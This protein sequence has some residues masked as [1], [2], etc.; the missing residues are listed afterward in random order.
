MVGKWKIFLF[1]LSLKQIHLLAFNAASSCTYSKTI[2]TKPE[3]ACT[4]I[5]SSPMP[6]LFALDVA[7]CWFFD[8]NAVLL[9][10]H[11]KRTH[12]ASCQIGNKWKIFIKLFA[13]RHRK[14][15]LCFGKQSHWEQEALPLLQRMNSH[16]WRRRI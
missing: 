7:L 14:A 16:T 1:A 15:R 3:P 11:C 4:Y 5:H 10:Y 8:F 12:N 6:Q 13:F 9:C 2:N